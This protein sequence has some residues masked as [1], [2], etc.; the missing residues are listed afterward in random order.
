MTRA[1]LRRRIASLGDISKGERNA[2]VCAF[3][4]HSKIVT[5][6]FGYV[7]CAR[8]EAKIGDTLGGATELSSNVIVEHDCPT[9][10][11]NF[12]KLGWADK[13]YTP[14]PFPKEKKT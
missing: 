5:Y 7:H 11:A 6:C 8:C 3:L 1:E 2:I 14:T 12:A 13:L 4:G 9:C 10:R